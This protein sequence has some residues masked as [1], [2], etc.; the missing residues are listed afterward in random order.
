MSIYVYCGRK[1]TGALELVNALGAKRL[2]KFD[3]LHFRDKTRR[4][5]LKDGDVVICWGE[6]VPEFDGVRVLNALD[7][8]LNKQNELKRLLEK[9][10]PCV[11]VSTSQ[12]LGP[13]S[14]DRVGFI[15]R[16]NHHIGGNDLLNGIGRADYYVKKENFV[17]EYR[18]HSFN[19]R[20]I[21]AGIKVHREGFTLAA[22]PAAWLPNANLVHPW[23]R[24]F[25]GGWRIQYDDFKS[26]NR[27]RKIAHMAVAALGLT[28]GA[29]D[30]GELGD[31]TLKVLEVNRAPG[32]EGGTIASYTRAI[33]KWLE[34]PNE[35]PR[36]EEG[37]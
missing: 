22:S 31:G 10:V 24:S 7:A 20:S 26:T 19:G 29:V 34:R 3:G 2:R 16:S 33:N 5:N 36:P 14:L 11:R 9:G 32:I 35:A 13:D 1:S 18:I 17:K 15:K 8:P 27:Q 37:E 21:R 25:D 12:E 23:V 4:H 6:S 28:F 30:V